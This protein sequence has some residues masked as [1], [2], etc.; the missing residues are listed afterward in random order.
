MSE[1]HVM[2][3]LQNVRPPVTHLEAVAP[4]FAKAWVFHGDHE[5]KLSR[6]FAAIGDRVTL[7]P[8]SR[9][10]KNALDFHLSFYL[11]YVA[12][13]HPD[14][15]LVVVANDK[16][17][18]PMIEHAV[19]LGFAVRREGYKEPAKQA[20]KKKVANAKKGVTVKKKVPPAKKA[21]SKK[22]ASTGM[23]APA[24]KLVPA[25]KKT[26]A[27]KNIPAAKKAST[28]SKPESAHA[29]TELTLKE[30]QRIAKGIA[31]MGDKR[32]TK[33]SAFL[34]HLGSM[35]G[36]EPPAEAVGQAAE[37]LRASGVVKIDANKVK[38]LSLKP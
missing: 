7:V 30:L 15:R 2:V 27:K 35:L 38:Y 3:D 20:T 24:K 11:G 13:K 32:P 8:I 29:S 4:G 37:Y 25:K 22:A 26:A 19:L 17:Y 33:L 31:K 23:A 6:E 36:K 12:A 10:G 9:P 28:P 14:A 21:T 18:E 1:L 34:R 16:G 5:E